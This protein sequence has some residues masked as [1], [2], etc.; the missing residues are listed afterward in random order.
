[1]ESFDLFCR[2]TFST[3]LLQYILDSLSNWRS[4]YLD[5]Q[6]FCNNQNMSS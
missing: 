4:I 1:M 5:Y 2:E 3:L 6:D